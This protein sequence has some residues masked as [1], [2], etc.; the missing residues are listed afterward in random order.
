MIWW[1]HFRSIPCEGCLV[2]MLT[3]RGDQQA[4]PATAPKKSENLVRGMWIHFFSGEDFVRGVCGHSFLPV[5]VRV[6]G[7][8]PWSL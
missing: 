8:Q 1:S 2:V 4:L 6:C 3:S 5:P 7:A